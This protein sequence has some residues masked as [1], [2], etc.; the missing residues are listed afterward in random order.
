M[1][2]QLFKLLFFGCFGIA[3]EIVFVAITNLILNTPL[4][5]EPL[6]SLTGKTYVWMFPIYMLIPIIGGPLMKKVK[7][8]ALIIRLFTYAIAIFSIEFI[9]GFLLEAITGKCPWEYTDGWHICGYIQLEFLP[10]WM[11]F[12]FI[13][14]QLYYYID[15]HLESS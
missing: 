14:E 3:T 13:I 2:K 15:T 12:A 7:P 1:K 5:N 6:W 4:W 11:L 8:Y 9:S 10:A